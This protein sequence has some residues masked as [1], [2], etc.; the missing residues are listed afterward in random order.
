MLNIPETQARGFLN[1]LVADGTIRP[2]ALLR[3]SLTKAMKTE[4][5]APK[6]QIQKRLDM[7]QET[8]AQKAEVKTSWDEQD[9]VEDEN[10]PEEEE[11]RSK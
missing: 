7:K 10:P 3:N 8:T 4:V 2:E 9:L 6:S 1:N 11:G 5:D